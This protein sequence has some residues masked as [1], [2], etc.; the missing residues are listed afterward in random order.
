M[1]GATTVSRMRLNCLRAE[2]IFGGSCSHPHRASGRCSDAHR[3]THTLRYTE[4]TPS[5]T[6]QHHSKHRHGRSHAETQCTKFLSWGSHTY[7]DS[8]QTPSRNR[9]KPTHTH[10]SVL[11]IYKR[12]KQ[13]FGKG[14]Q[15]LGLFQVRELS[16]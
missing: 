5:F 3:N 11:S 10:K 15:G 6:L 13:N 14:A 8:Y 12:T 1:A 7:T 9:Y 4:R 16:E 2:G